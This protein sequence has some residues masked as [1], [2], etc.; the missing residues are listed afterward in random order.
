MSSE[1][2]KSAEPLAAALQTIVRELGLLNIN[3]NYIDDGE[4]PVLITLDGVLDSTEPGNTTDE[5]IE[6]VT[7]KMK[8]DFKNCNF[9]YDKQGTIAVMPIVH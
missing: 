5:D 7:N 9:T 3:A 2:I 4:L 6:Y 8:R 1:S